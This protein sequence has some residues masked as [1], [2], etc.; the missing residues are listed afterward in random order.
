MVMS[1]YNPNTEEVEVGEFS[2]TQYIYFEILPV[3]L[4]F[5][6]I[7]LDSTVE[8]KSVTLNIRCLYYN[9]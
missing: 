2:G 8:C 4:A 7:G 9:S 3:R 5:S 6:T 1:A